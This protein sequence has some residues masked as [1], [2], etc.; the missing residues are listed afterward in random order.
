MLDIREILLSA[1][2]P[3]QK[4]E[5]RFYIV[6]EDDGKGYIVLRRHYLYNPSKKTKP[7]KIALKDFFGSDK[8]FTRKTPKAM[9]CCKKGKIKGN[10]KA[11]KKEITAL[12]QPAK[13]KASAKPKA[14]KKA[15]STKAKH[16]RTKKTVK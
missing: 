6:G 7:I 5:D 3:V 11:V 12:P 1:N 15:V 9:S 4:R 10:K 2:I 13:L 16:S 14:T 8:C